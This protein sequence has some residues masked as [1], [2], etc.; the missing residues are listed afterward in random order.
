MATSSG[1]SAEFAV[2]PAVATALGIAILI[3]LGVWQVQRL[4]W[5][6]ALLARITALQAAPPEPLEVVLRRATDGLDIDYVRVQALCP[7]VETAPYLRLYAVR[8]ARA[9]YRII[10]ACALANAPYGSILVDRGFIPEGRTPSGG[11]ALSAPIVG[12][13]RKGDSRNFVTPANQPAQNLWY[14]RDIPAMARALGAGRPAPTFLMLEQPAP[15]PGGPEIAPLPADIPNNHLQYAITW[16]GL[17]VALAGV[18]LASL[19]AKRRR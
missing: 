6:E 16:F 8:D 2:T 15:P 1:A 10:A 13:L 12:I 9:G 14:W 19:W 17:A 5:K 7:A 3:G 18:Y 11:Q 4:R